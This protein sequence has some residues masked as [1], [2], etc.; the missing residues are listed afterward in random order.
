M[1]HTGAA[2]PENIMPIHYGT[3]EDGQKNVIFYSLID[4]RIYQ[5]K[6]TKTKQNKKIESSFTAD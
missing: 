1:H 4:L 2:T 5:K 3:I 6:K